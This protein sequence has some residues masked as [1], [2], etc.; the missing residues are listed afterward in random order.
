M[1]DQ[2]E[3]LIG[4]VYDEG[5]AADLAEVQRHIDACPDCRAE[6]AG[7]R[8]ART[9]LLA[10]EVP[11][12]ESVWRP[13]VAAPVM[14]W[15]RQVPAWAMAAAAGVM[16]VFGAAGS[17]VVHAFLPDQIVARQFEAA[18]APAPG[19]TAADLSAVEQRVLA[20]MRSQVGAVDARVQ[21]VAGRP[22]LASLTDDHAA[23]SREVVELRERNRRLGNIM[24]TLVSNLD[25]VSS[26]GDAKHAD[27]QSQLNNLQAIVAQ[28]AQVK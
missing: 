24:N 21:Q 18:N 28:L 26:A 25:Q 10:W 12:H 8:S 5:D 22:F 13:F 7:L 16:F 27:L 6:V 9:D 3:R 4:Y 17:V 14:P 1:C 11:A 2:R 23:L 15:W 19:L 20:E